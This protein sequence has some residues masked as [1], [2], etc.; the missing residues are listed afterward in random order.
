[1]LHKDAKNIDIR[2]HA[3]RVES[4]ESR[5]AL[6]ATVSAAVFDGNLVILGGDSA[7]QV[8][9]TLE[10]TEVVVAGLDGATLIN[11]MQDVRFD[12]SDIYGNVIVDLG[13]SDNVLRLGGEAH[14]ET[15]IAAITAADE[16]GHD[17]EARL[18][19]P[20]DLR[21][22]TEGGDDTIRISFV[23]VGGRVTV[24]SVRVPTSSMSAAA[25]VSPPRIMAR[26]PWSPQY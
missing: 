5:F 17:E 23:E 1:M 2:E 16:E 9:V 7:D 6:S 19:I 15:A 25:R 24:E 20:G 4:L 22:E 12:A 8:G 11:G 14:E 13:S 3:L 10:G 26:R 18:S 21:V